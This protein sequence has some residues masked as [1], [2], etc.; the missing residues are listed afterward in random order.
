MATMQN[1]EL[2]RNYLEEVF[3]RRNLNAVDQYLS[4]AFVDHNPY[5]P[6]Q[7]PG[8]AGR[9]QATSRFHEAF[10]DFHLAIESIVAEGDMVAV[11][12]TFSGRQTGSFMG[13]P[14]TGQRVAWQGM[15][16]FRVANGRITE[17]WSTHDL[18]GLLQ[19]V[20][21]IPE[22]IEVPAVR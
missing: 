4:P 20:G 8:P 18:L 17:R 14:P 22:R 13:V 19:Q 15:G 7:A 2:V 6:Q 11:R 5:S 9:K 3:N 10:A 16:F 1:K 12:G 21:I